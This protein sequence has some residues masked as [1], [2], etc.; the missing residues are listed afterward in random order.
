LEQGKTIIP[1]I[2]QDFSKHA[3]P[4]PAHIEEVL[5]FNGLVIKDVENFQ[6]PETT[7]KLAEMIRV[8]AE[9]L[10]GL[11]RVDAGEVEAEST[12][13]D[14]KVK[15]IRALVVDDSGDFRE[16]LQRILE[17]EFGDYI[18]VDVV[19]NKA[20]AIAHIQANIYDL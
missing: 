2:Q 11:I 3:H 1:L 5:K 18:I 19:Q 4:L 14:L 20:E 10:A 9:Q 13:Y 12:I 16:I 7:A 6:I 17:D 15:Q 8:V